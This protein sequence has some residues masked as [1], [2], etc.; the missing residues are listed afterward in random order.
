MIRGLAEYYISF[1]HWLA[2]RARRFDALACGCQAVNAGH[3]GALIRVQ[4][5][6]RA[7]AR[8]IMHE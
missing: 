7:K 1:F 6:A 5:P 8:V 4:R 2:K 3:P